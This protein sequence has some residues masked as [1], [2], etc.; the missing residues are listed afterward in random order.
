[1][2]PPE[3]DGRDENHALGGEP[4][5]HGAAVELESDSAN[6]SSA[7]SGHSVRGGVLKSPMPGR[8]LRVSVSTGELVSA[9]TE[10]LV[11]EAM[12]ME[13][14]LFAPCPGRVDAVWV[15]SGQT[16][17]AQADLLSVVADS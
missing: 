2:H 14:R 10:V 5:V 17:E 15:V 16:V 1:V 6:T 11:I 12:K 4:R 9:D 7:R 8:I 13:N 3:V